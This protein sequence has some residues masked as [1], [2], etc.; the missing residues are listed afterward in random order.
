MGYLP[1][2]KGPAAR[3]P[4]VNEGHA[5]CAMG[6]TSLSASCSPVPTGVIASVALT[7]RLTLATPPRVV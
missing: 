6:A 1:Y 7:V 5:A 2:N 4:P 3:R